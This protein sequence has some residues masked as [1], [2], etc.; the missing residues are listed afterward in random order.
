MGADVDGLACCL[1]W[2]TN[3]GR[4][5]RVQSLLTDA[6]LSCH[7][8]YASAVLDRLSGGCEAPRMGHLLWY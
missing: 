7:T 8:V 4:Y 2:P 1:H 5:M 6:I 3:Y